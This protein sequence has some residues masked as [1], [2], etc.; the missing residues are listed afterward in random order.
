[1]QA[2]LGR[3]GQKHESIHQTVL[4]SRGL[5]RRVL[6][7]FKKLFIGFRE[8]VGPALAADVDPEAVGARRD[9]V[10]AIVVCEEHWLWGAHD[11]DSASVELIEVDVFRNV[12][13][14]LFNHGHLMKLDGRVKV[15]AKIFEDS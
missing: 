6:V 1:M 4:A 14:S 3:S 13:S 5:T 2:T 11:A 12:F 7:E 10:V 8:K 15:F 9:P